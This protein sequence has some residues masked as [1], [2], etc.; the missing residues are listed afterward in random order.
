MINTYKEFQ[1]RGIPAENIVC[2]EMQRLAYEY[3]FV[4]FKTSDDKTNYSRKFDDG[5]EFDGGLVMEVDQL[6]SNEAEFKS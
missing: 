6:P 3:A 5:Y 4:F 2:Q 1:K